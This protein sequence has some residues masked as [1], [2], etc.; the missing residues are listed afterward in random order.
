VEVVRHQAPG[1]QLPLVESHGLVEETK[2]PP[3]RRVVG[4]DRQL[5]HS[6]TDEV[7]DPPCNLRAQWPRHSCPFGAL[8]WGQTPG[9]VSIEQGPLCLGN[10]IFKLLGTV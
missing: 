10:G 9:L 8:S 4:E 3:A 7:V 6:A 1:V 2:E 5:P